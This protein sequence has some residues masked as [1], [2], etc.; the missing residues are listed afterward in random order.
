VALRIGIDNWR[1]A[2]VPF[3]LRTGKRL[4]ARTTEIAVHFRQAPYALFRDTPVEHLPPNILMLRIQPDEGLSISFSAKRPGQEIE[5]DGVAM[6]F[7]YS[8]YFAPV[9]AVGYETLIYDCLLGDATLFQ[10]ADTVEA[11]WQAIQPLLDAWSRDPPKDF[12]NYAAGSAGPH[13]ADLLLARDGRKWLPIGGNRAPPDI[14]AAQQ[15]SRLKV[16]S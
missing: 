12:P 16:T 14:P 13:T 2:G 10:R 15:R 8:S 1:W 5:I 3:Y 7:A 4:A 11:A 6:D 9:V